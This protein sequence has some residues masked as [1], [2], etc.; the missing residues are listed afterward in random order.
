MRALLA[1][2]DLAIANL[3][4]FRELVAAFGF[5]CPSEEHFTS[6]ARIAEALRRLV[7]FVEPRGDVIVTMGE[8]GQVIYDAADG[9]IFHMG[10]TREGQAICR[11]YLS[12]GKNQRNRRRLRC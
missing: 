7:Q 10:L 12:G 1:N 3:A 5:D 2:S 8:S 6:V 11:S 4:E 9:A